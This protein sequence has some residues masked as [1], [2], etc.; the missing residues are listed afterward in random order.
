MELGAKNEVIVGIETLNN[1]N[2]FSGGAGGN[3]KASTES[4]DG[5]MMIGIDLGNWSKNLGSNTT[6][7]SIDAMTAADKEIVVGWGGDSGW[8]VG[9]PRNDVW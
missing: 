1:F 9:L 2:Y 7:N 6:R 3:T 5:L 8:V 4:A